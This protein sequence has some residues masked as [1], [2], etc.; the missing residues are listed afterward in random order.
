MCKQCSRDAVMW[1]SEGFFSPIINK[2][3]VALN[4]CKQGHSW[5]WG[6]PEGGVCWQPQRS[7]TPSTSPL[8]PLAAAHQHIPTGYSNTDVP[9]RGPAVAPFLLQAQHIMSILWSN[10]SGL[11]LRK[12]VIVHSTLQPMCGPHSHHHSSFSIFGSTL[13]R[14][15]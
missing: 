9:F 10:L 14:L 2:K 11:F 1:K 3:V 7:L 4:T 6:F 13:F 12:S 5:R 15:V 8:L